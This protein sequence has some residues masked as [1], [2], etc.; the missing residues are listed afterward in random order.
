[1]EKELNIEG[2]VAFCVSILSF[3]SVLVQFLKW[4]AHTKCLS[5]FS[6]SKALEQAKNNSLF[7]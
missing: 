4:T 5:S 7:L 2:L 3:I 6:F 1:M